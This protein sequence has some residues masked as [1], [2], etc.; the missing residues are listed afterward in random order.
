VATAEATSPA[1]VTSAEDTGAA[2][3]QV[4]GTSTGGGL[5]LVPIA[6]VAVL[7]V[8]VVVGLTVRRRRG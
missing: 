5:P 1:A 2:V 8:F 3:Q 6:V 7:A 4:S